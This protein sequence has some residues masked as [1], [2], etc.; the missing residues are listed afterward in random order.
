MW[1]Y[2]FW[3]NNRMKTIALVLL[4]SSALTVSVKAES[5]G[6]PREDNKTVIIYSTES[7]QITENQR[8]LDM[9]VSHF[10]SNLIMKNA[11]DLTET[12]LNKASTLI[13][14]GETAD[15]LPDSLA[16]SIDSF[17]GTVMAI[18]HNKEQLGKRFGFFKQHQ[19]AAIN[20]L[21]LVKGN[22]IRKMEDMRVITAITHN[23]STEVLVKGMGRGKTYPLFIRNENN[24][25]FS[26]DRIDSLFSVYLGEVLHDV[27]N[28]D[29]ERE[30]PAYLRLEDI[31]PLTD[32][33]VLKE[34]AVILK[35]KNIPY[36]VSVIPVYRDPE[37][38]EESRFTDYPEVL[39][40]LKFMQKNG[41]SIIVHGYTHQYKD[42]ET[43]E[44]FEFWDVD[45]NMPITVPANETPI[46]KKRSDFDSEKA[47]LEHLGKQKAFE[48]DY[49]KS[50]VNSAIQEMVGLGLYPLAFEAPHY[51][52]SQSGY[53]ILADHFSTYIGQLQL[54]DRDWRIMA[55]SPYVSYPSF[56]HGMKLLPET[57]GYVEPD[58]PH[59]IEEMIEAA[60][61]QLIVRDGYVAGFYHPYLGVERFKDLMEQL[62]KI[63][64]LSWIDLAKMNNYVGVDNISL[65]AGVDNDVELSIN[66]FG[67][68]KSSPNYYK[69]H[70]K[71]AVN[72]TLWMIVAAAGLMVM[73]FTYYAIRLNIRRARNGGG[74]F[75]E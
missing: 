43:G 64:N 39:D 27:F 75:D 52:M 16:E 8:L 55:A 51:T 40:A 65:T 68:L 29:H 47:Y 59:A 9:L 50:K 3:L 70:V 5:D 12:D 74:E 33:Y 48:T 14:Y 30:N 38:G 17:P 6:D 1:I 4:I 28:A 15:V 45:A 73:M 7:G 25:F 71:S 67:L 61:D 11:K 31:H 49:I 34:I 18:S 69:P 32:P 41:G 22:K 10:S 21:V 53:E 56:L 54:G 35:K 42:D 13:Y 62:E 72:S 19:P 66:Y 20:Q 57:I 60:K 58:N 46:V 2:Q 36:I 37:T 63:P 24:Y 23:A 26:S 44:G